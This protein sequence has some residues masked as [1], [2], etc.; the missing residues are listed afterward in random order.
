MTTPTRTRLALVALAAL[1]VAGSAAAGEDESK[2][3]FA[4]GRKLRE[5]GKCAEAIDAFRR[6]LEAWPEGLGSLRNIAECQEALGQY[7]SARRSFWDLRRGALQSDEA[8]YDGWEDTADAAYARLEPLV[9]RLTLHVLGADV[10]KVRV[11]LDGE[12]LTRKMLGVPLERDVGLHRVEVW[13][14]GKLLE[15]REVQLDASQAEVVS[16]EVTL[17]R[18]ATPREQPP[19]GEPSM[20]LA[21]AGWATLGIGVVGLGGAIAAAVVREGALSDLEACPT[22]DASAPSTCPPEFEEARDRGETAT[23]LFNVLGV[24]AIVGIGA[25]VPMV[26]VGMLDDTEASVGVLPNGLFGARLRY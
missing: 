12:D 9:P 10:T 13:H 22:F 3:F 11:R 7:A 8:K 26:V 17:P 24:V 20:A 19:P 14:E 4:E 16:I 2:S 18:K 1:L 21:A 5:A 15:K 6:A 25:G 23:T